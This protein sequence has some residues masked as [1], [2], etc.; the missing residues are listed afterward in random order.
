MGRLVSVLSFALSIPSVLLPIV[1][2][3]MEHASTGP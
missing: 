2:G 1:S 3:S